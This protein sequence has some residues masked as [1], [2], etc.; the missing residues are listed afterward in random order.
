MRF[1]ATTVL[2][3]GILVMMF[4]PVLERF[5]PGPNQEAPLRPNPRVQIFPPE[6]LRTH[7]IHKH[8]G[9]FTCLVILQDKNCVVAPPATPKGP[10]KMKNQAQYNNRTSNVWLHL[11]FS[12]NWNAYSL[13]GAWSSTKKCPNEKKSIEKSGIYSQF[14]CSLQYYGNQASIHGS[15]RFHQCVLPIS[16][17]SQIF[18]LLVHFLFSFE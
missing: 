17:C 18:W 12:Q 2:K 4:V 14:W 6:Y 1:F 15:I 8:S 16:V 9:N 5:R 7:A 3:F 13:P 11:E 10:S